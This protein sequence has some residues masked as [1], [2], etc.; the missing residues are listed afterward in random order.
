M[1]VQRDVWKQQQQ[2][3]LIR[4]PYHISYTFV[5]VC[6]H[7]QWPQGLPALVCVW[8]PTGIATTEITLELGQIHSFF[9]TAKENPPCVCC[10]P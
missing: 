8:F 5:E 3:K 6:H 2:N 7:Q 4:S 1:F 10:G 9:K